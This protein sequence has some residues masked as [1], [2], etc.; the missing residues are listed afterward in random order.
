MTAELLMRLVTQIPFLIIFAV[1]FLEWRRRPSKTGTDATLFFGLIALLQVSGWALELTGRADAPPRWVATLNSSLLMALPYLL[2]RLTDDFAGVPRRLMR[3]A[4]VGLVLSVAVLVARDPATLP[5][6]LAEFLV[7]YFAGFQLYAATRFVKAARSTHGVTRFRMRAAAAGS[8]LIGLVIVFAGLSLALPGGEAWGVLAQVA[9][10]ASAACYLGAFSP[11]VALQ[12]FLIEPVLRELM[13]PSTLRIGESTPEAIARVIE[14]AALRASG[15]A[16]ADV[17]LVDEAGVLRAVDVSPED[18]LLD[19]P[20]ARRAF[21]TQATVYA[22]GG[23]RTARESRFAYVHGFESTI[24]APITGGEHRFGVLQTFTE[25]SPLF[26]E[27]T[28]LTVEL[29]ARQAAVF[30]EG[31]LLTEEVV[32]ARAQ[33]ELIRLKDDF[34]SAVAHDLRTPLTTLLGQA[35]LLERR[36]RRA[37]EAPTDPEGVRRLVRAAERM[38]S[39]V[40]G[41]LDV[42]RAERA[43]FTA[44]PEPVDLREI[45]VEVADDFPAS[46]HRIVVRADASVAVSADRHRIGEVLQNLLSNAVKYS[47][48]GG[49]V[50]VSL[51][52][53]DGEAIVSVSDQ[54]IGIAE[55][56]LPNLFT[57]FWRA[58]HLDESHFTG[59]GLGLYICERIMS[60]H[61]GRIWATSTKGVGS[62]FH[63][64][65]PLLHE[66]E[67]S[68]A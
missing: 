32:E 28:V 67:S 64:A 2:L 48:G 5:T 41:M 14:N 61:G 68:L 66:R 46:G 39:L 10:A 6:I 18:A 12:R 33:A 34:F 15:A 55:D 40:N 62:T 31:H 7:V 56:Q 8:T 43:A 47:P 53:Q 60:G 58:P 24:A 50:E 57:R 16:R 65:L 29:M 35:Q 52:E 54:G 37:P 63:I 45:V 25:R 36:L 59:L 1:V 4:E 20:F 30:L 3:L 13:G 49:T 51:C 17:L 21:D 11:P 9:G 42:S 22:G 27:E 38:T 19:R 44:T 26:A 23:E